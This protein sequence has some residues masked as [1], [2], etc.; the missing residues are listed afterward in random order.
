MPKEV[1]KSWRQHK[2]AYSYCHLVFKEVSKNER[3]PQK[4]LLAKYVAKGLTGNL[5]K[6][7]TCE[8][9]F[10]KKKTHLWDSKIKIFICKHTTLK[11]VILLL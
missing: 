7:L 3:R 8:F 9:H 10:G 2:T 4:T 6:K 5:K 11:L 1:T